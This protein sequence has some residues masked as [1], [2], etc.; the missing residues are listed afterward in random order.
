MHL[1]TEIQNIKHKWTHLE[2]EIITIRFIDICRE[3][4]HSVIEE[5]TEIYRTLTKLIVQLQKKYFTE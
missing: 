5:Y 2:E 3:N 4:S 1:L